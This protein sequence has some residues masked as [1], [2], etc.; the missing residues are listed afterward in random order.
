[1]DTSLS[2]DLIKYRNKI[3]VELILTTSREKFLDE[4]DLSILL[5]GF[6]Y[7]SSSSPPDRTGLQSIGPGTEL[8]AV[9]KEIFRHHVEEL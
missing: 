7:S 4:I 5:T 6:L 2:L 8:D 1:L 3:S 9:M